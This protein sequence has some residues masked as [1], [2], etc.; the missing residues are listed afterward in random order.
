MS[1]KCVDVAFFSAKRKEGYADRKVK[2]YIGRYTS[3]GDTPFLA[4]YRCLFKFA[5]GRGTKESERSVLSNV[6]PRKLAAV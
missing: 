4:G 5:N 3:S 1:T 2:N 6:F